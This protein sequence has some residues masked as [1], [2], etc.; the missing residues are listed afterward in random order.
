MKHLCRTE[1]NN[2]E[3][4]EVKI[5]SMIRLVELISPEK[6]WSR[7]NKTN[8]QYQE[9]VTTDRKRITRRYKKHYFNKF[10]FNRKI[11]FTK[12]YWNKLL[13]QEEM[14]WISNLIPS[15]KHLHKKIQSPDELINEILQTLKK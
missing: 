1:K 9:Q 15:Q 14:I 3:N 6:E 10:N 11:Q 2:R 4:N 13:K 5:G 8:C 12:K 7:K